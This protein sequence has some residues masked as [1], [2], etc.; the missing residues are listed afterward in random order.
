[1]LI[2]KHVKM[3]TS[4]EKHQI[5]PEWFPLNSNAVSLDFHM[6]KF[7]SLLSKQSFYL[8]WCFQF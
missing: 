2:Y 6:N 5:H 8:I 4:K 1:M 7:L 3:F